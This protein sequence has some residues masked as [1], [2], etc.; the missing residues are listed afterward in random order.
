MKKLS[1]IVCVYNTDK[2]YLAE[3]LESITESTLGGCADLP[4]A[5]YEILLIDDGSSV[6]Y[7]DIVEKYGVRYHKTEN[8]G[9]F[10]ARLLGIE[11]AE[12]EYIAFCDSDDTVTVNYHRPML[13]LA[14]RDGAEIVINDWAFRTERSR[15]Y[16]QS[17]ETV[18]DDIYLEN[19]G[20]IT[21]F[22]AQSGRMHS[23]YVLWNKVFSS[24]LLKTVAQT[25]RH[26]AEGEERFNYSEDALMS[27]H[28]FRLAKRVENLHTGY[29]FY[30]IHDSQSV[31]VASEEKLLRQIECMKKTLAEM[32]SGVAELNDSAT[33]F[34]Y[35]DEWARLMSRTHYSYAKKGG[36]R[37]LYPIIKEAYG[38]DELHSSYHSD[39]YAYSKTALIG[40][41]I[42]DIDR[43]LLDA[44][45]NGTPIC[46]KELE[47]YAQRVIEGMS[48]IGGRVE[49]ADSE[50]L[51]IPKEYVSFK[52]KLYHNPLVYKLG[53]TLFP[54]GSRIRAFLKRKL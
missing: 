50:G 35:V 2:V 22:L 40:S 38:V 23:Y 25:V 34:R 14:K 45:K 26:I 11:L 19:D 36:Y 53:M 6:D 24:E 28:A 44:F 39:S 10:R 30:R 46:R 48:E 42:T 37:S 17:D 51:K 31:A 7:T 43:L 33:L 29:Y 32:K 27:F 4:S 8:R 49:F 20:C 13:E 5:D 12:G 47:P 15:Y 52:R 41:N 21:A 9:I 3:C 1:I 18:R 54:K 16:C